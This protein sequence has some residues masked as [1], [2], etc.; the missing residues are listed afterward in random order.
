MLSRP[1]PR[2]ALSLLPLLSLGLSLLLTISCMSTN[3][4]PI[5][6]YGERFEPLGDEVLVWEEAMAEEEVLLEN[7]QL[8]DDPRLESYLEGIVARL[9]SDGMAANPDIRYQ[10][11]VIEDSSLNA[12][13]Y[14]HG[15]IY[16]HTGLLSRMENEDQL[17]TVLAHEMTHVENRHMVRHRRSAHN[18]RV[19]FGIAAVA[20]AVILAESE[21]DA[22]SDGDW[23]R[24]L[25]IEI[26]GDLFLGFGLEMAV[27]ASVRGYGRDLERE[28]DDGGL[29]KLTAAGYDLAEA[30]KVYQALLDG[31]DPEYGGGVFFFASHPKLTR[32]VENAQAWLTAHP[33]HQPAPADAAAFHASTTPLLLHEAEREMEA[34]RLDLTELYLGKVWERQPQ[35]EEAAGLAERLAAARTEE[36]AAVLAGT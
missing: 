11:R 10:V 24:G 33:A 20:A 29:A 26:L 9:E 19:G 7:A 4:P 28:A 21:W 18:K 14:P 23:G 2:P 35:S 30:P 31:K 25:R 6:T 34:G 1:R 12:F 22:Y 13:A 16:L 3:L 32:R 8:Y 17:A 5:S 36:E 15:S 27:M